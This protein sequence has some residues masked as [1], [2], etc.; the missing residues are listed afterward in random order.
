MNIKEGHESS[1]ACRRAQ[2]RLLR[3]IHLE[4][5]VLS[6]AAQIQTPSDVLWD[7]KPGEWLVPR[8][9]TSCLFKHNK[10]PHCED[11]G[12]FSD[13]VLDSGQAGFGEQGTQCYAVHN[14]M[15]RLS[16]N[17][18]SRLALAPIPT[19]ALPGLMIDVCLRCGLALEDEFRRF[20]L[21]TLNV[22]EV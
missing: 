12:S 22:F 2:R 13:E 17:C 11:I 18:A 8:S 20:G 3:L 21:S 19:S 7:S 10:G 15:L 1:V 14:M 6:L 4:K 16:R 9:G 5:S